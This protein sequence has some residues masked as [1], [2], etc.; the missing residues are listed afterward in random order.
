MYTDTDLRAEKNEITARSD[1][2]DGPISGERRET[3]LD[4]VE[5]FEFEFELELRCVCLCGEL[6]V[7]FCRTLDL[8][9]DQSCVP[10]SLIKM[11]Y[12]LLYLILFNILKRNI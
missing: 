5:E 4:R 2:G 8:Y 1:G 3:N 11:S 10:I 12:N 6:V 7:H 9:Y